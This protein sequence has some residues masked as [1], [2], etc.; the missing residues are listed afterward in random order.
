[1]VF[2]YA[3]HHALPET[4]TFCGGKR[5]CATFLYGCVLYA[6][7]YVAVMNLRLRHGEC[8]DSVRSA[9][10]MAWLADIAAVGF[11]YKSYYGRSLLHEVVDVGGDGD[12][13]TWIFDEETHR[14]R[15]PTPADELARRAAEDARL[16]A[17]EARLA[18]RLERT[19]AAERSAEIGRN[20]REI[21]AAK[22]IQRWWRSVLYTPPGGI[23]YLRAKESWEHKAVHA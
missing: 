22:V 21:R 2:Y 19:A 11:L 5:N 23:F 4:D 8:F 14:Y 17:Q 1:M 20:K 12:Q 18:K 3:L 9:V 13:R 16:A 15:R 7:V 6:I 10:L